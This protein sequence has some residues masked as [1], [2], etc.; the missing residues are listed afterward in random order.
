MQ[1]DGE[2]PLLVEVVLVERRRWAEELALVL[3]S[4]GVDSQVGQARTPAGPRYTLIVDEA[5]GPR[6]THELRQYT[7]ENRG[8]RR[9]AEPWLAQPGAWRGSLV[10]VLLLALGFAFQ[11]RAGGLWEA[12]LANAGAIVHGEVWLAMTSLLLHADFL[13]L[14]S[15]VFFGALL[16]SFVA[17]ELGNTLAWLGI[18]MAGWLGNLINAAVYSIGLG[19]EHLSLGASTAV[20][21][22]VGLLSMLGFASKTQGDSLGRRL[23]PLVM[24]VVMLGLYGISGENTDVLAHLFGLIAGALV[25]LMG[26]WWGRRGPIPAAGT[27]A[28]LALG[29][30]AL[31]CVLAWS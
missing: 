4:R 23:A 2:L 16:G 19:Q 14:A 9:I 25:F 30:L 20:F 13:H 7:D 21:G 11:A 29:L 6:A 18:L 17:V 1:T 3:A 24:G 27:R 10:Y 5:E 8:V 12:G 22:A 26:A 31:A 15:N 28:Y